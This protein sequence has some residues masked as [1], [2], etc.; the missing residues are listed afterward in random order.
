M[1]QIEETLAGILQQL[2]E[3]QTSDAN[4]LRPKTPAAGAADGS[5]EAESSTA[6]VDGTPKP[7]KTVSFIQRSHCL[8]DH[9]EVGSLA[10][11][12]TD[13]DA[14]TAES[15]ALV[16]AAAE[17]EKQ[18]QLLD[19]LAEQIMKEYPHGVPVSCNSCCVY[20][21]GRAAETP[22]ALAYAMQQ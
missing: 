16:A 3:Y 4:P 6:A 19:E 21:S 14:V 12:G 1:K 20:V 22:A 10:P 11:A 7:C 2:P 8:K 17:Q 5:A 15:A 18:Q 9:L 13:A